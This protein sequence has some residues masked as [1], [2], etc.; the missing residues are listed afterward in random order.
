MT[1]PARPPQRLALRRLLARAAILFEAL[2]PALWPPLGVVGLYLCAGLLGLPQALPTLLHLLVLLLAVAATAYLGW[3]GLHRVRF[4]DRRSADRRLETSSGLTHRPLSV[5]SDKPAGGDELSQAVWRA[6]AARAAAQIGRLR[7]GAPHPGLARRDPRAIRF[8]LVLGL[9]AALVIAGPDAPS[10]VLAALTPAM[11]SGLPGQPVELQAWIT[12]PAY[13]RVAPIFLK[14]QGGTVSVPAGSHLTVNVSGGESV[15]TLALN[16]KSDPFAPLDRTSFQAER[17]LGRGGTLTVRR[18]GHTMAA[19][20]LTVVG[21]LPPTVEWGE[22]PGRQPM[23]QQTRLPW[24]VADDYGVVS[25][26]AELR[27]KARPGAPPLVTTIPLPGGSPKDA[28]GVSQQ[29]M[30]AHPW[31]GLPV[32]ARLVAKDAAGQTGASANIEFELPE[33][34]FRHPIAR[35]LIA[36]RKTLSLHPDDRGDALEILDGLMQQPQ[37]FRGDVGAFTNLSAIYYQ[38]VRDKSPAAV[39][40]AQQMMWE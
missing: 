37:A 29:D 34:P 27:L 1:D 30:T 17:D 32:T 8:A 6:H 25:L 31:A 18:D 15:P 36:A 40:Q 28:H 20:S 13:T 14:A 19:W 5:L 24:K 4:P 26:Q 39:P 12:P 38:L 21:D 23:S 7:V 3:R 11:P 2:W 10:R 16:D 35:A 22:Q 9:V 33:R